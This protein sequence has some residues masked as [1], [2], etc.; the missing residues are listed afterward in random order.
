V[1]A[2]DRRLRL[3][4]LIAIWAGLI[5]VS[6]TLGVADTAAGTTGSLFPTALELGLPANAAAPAEQ[7][8][9]FP[10]SE[11]HADLDSVACTSV[12]NCVAVGDFLTEPAGDPE[13]YAEQESLL[14][15]QERWR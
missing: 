14:G 6:A 7:N 10:R 15:G 4:R 11:Q 3:Y 1:W 5:A 8:V 13:A 9:S 2:S 12:G